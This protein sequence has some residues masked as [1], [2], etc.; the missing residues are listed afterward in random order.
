M[1]MRPGWSAQSC[2]MHRQGSGSASLGTDSSLELMDSPHAPLNLE[3]L[4]PWSLWC[5]RLQLCPVHDA[6]GDTT[7]RQDSACRSD[8]TYADAWSSPPQHIMQEAA[9]HPRLQAMLSGGLVAGKKL[10]SLDP[11]GGGICAL[12]FAALTHAADLA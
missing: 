6:S 2:W 9:T 11:A 10:A 5:V 3:E 1:L 4:D 12:A 8:S 7:L